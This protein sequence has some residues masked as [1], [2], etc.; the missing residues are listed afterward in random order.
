MSPR[1]RI[2]AYR[3]AAKSGHVQETEVASHERQE[4]I[5]GFRSPTELAL[6][7]SIDD[8]KVGRLT[9]THPFVDEEGRKTGVL[10]PLSL[11]GLNAPPPY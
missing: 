3:E 5:Q 9:D 8:A 1:Q 4:Q 6:H 11:Q 10:R 7:E 2:H